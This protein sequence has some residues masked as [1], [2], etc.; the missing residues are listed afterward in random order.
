MLICSEAFSA[1]GFVSILVL[2]SNIAKRHGQ[3]EGGLL[4]NQGG[5]FLDGPGTF[6]EYEFREP[7]G[8]SMNREVHWILLSRILS[9]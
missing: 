8:G 1:I 6:N 9:V 3:V 4:R 2:K 7:W 5:R